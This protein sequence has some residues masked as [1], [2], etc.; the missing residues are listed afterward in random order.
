MKVIYTFLNDITK[1]LK[2]K[3]KVEVYG[4]FIRHENKYITDI[5]LRMKM[6]K[7]DPN[8]YLF[9]I[10]NFIENYKKKKIIFE[11]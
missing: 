1:Y 5:D 11:N 9:S 4:S 7:N 6:N 2:N 10:L 3:G 8:D